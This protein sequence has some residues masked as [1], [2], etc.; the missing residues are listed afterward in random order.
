M[1]A[2]I[3]Q[4]ALSL[5]SVTFIGAGTASG[6]AQASCIATV[7]HTRTHACLHY[8]RA[9]RRCNKGPTHVWLL[10]A[11]KLWIACNWFEA[12]QHAMVRA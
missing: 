4:A 12:R 6:T 1:V 10:A 2:P 11:I 3:G 9:A 8:R 5:G 7:R